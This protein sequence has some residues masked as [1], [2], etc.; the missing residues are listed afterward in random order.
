MTNQLKFA[1]SPDPQGYQERDPVTE[2]VPRALSMDALRKQLYDRA[3]NLGLARGHVDSKQTKALI[4]EY[5]SLLARDV[6]LFVLARVNVKLD[7][8]D[9]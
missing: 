7:L 6:V 3:Y 8:M 5:T 2:E 1:F 4:D 9:V